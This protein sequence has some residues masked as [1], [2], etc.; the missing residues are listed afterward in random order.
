M[1]R[2]QPPF[3]I[4]PD[5]L[6]RAYA[7]G[8]FPMA[9]D[10]DSDQL[11]WVEPE[12]RGV[13]PLDGLTIS[14]SLAKTVRS[15]MYE[16]TADR[17]FGEVMRACA[18]RE[19]TWI[20]AEILRLYGELHARGHAHSIEARQGGELVGGLYGVSLGGAF[21]GESMFHRARD[22]SKVALTHL[23]ARLKRGRFRLLDTQ[24]VTSHLASLGAQEISRSEYRRRLAVALAVEADFETFPAHAVMTGAEALDLVRSTA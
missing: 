2:R 5:L 3:E 8:L 10:R 18:M 16:V 1:S 22:A 13:F 12:R 4:T 23:V 11:H 14:K 9:E 21:F 6:L 17:S 15:D 19:R 24:F 20:N 7:I